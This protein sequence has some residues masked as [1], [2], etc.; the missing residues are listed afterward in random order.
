MKTLSAKLTMNIKELYR[1]Y[2]P[3]DIFL[4]V[5]SCVFIISRMFPKEKDNFYPLCLIFGF[6]GSNSSNASL[7]PWSEWGQR[8]E[9]ELK[10]HFC[11]FYLIH[12]FLS[13]SLCYSSVVFSILYPWL[14]TDFWWPMK[15]TSPQLVSENQ[16]KTINLISGKAASAESIS[17][18]HIIELEGRRS[19]L[20]YWLISTW[21][22]KPG[23]GAVKFDKW[24]R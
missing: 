17:N 23:Q 3:K 12:I 21:K 8:E 4:Y 2:C 15:G 22:Q 7:I 13:C 10:S 6:V 20:L 1:Q 18:S 24:S 9:R 16:N 19:Y 11:V 5:F 14:V